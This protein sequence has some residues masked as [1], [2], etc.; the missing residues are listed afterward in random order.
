MFIGVFTFYKNKTITLPQKHSPRCPLSITHIYRYNWTKEN[1][2][3]MRKSART[4]YIRLSYSCTFVD[5]YSKKFKKGLQTWLNFRRNF[6]SNGKQLAG[7]VFLMHNLTHHFQA[8]LSSFSQKF[9][10]MNYHTDYNQCWALQNTPNAQ[11]YTIQCYC[12]QH[13]LD[14]NKT[15]IAISPTYAYIV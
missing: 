3:T 8:V 10:I 7:A 12:L 6:S 9:H 1:R 13:G 2:L 11:E 15:W 4:Y 14:H 5:G